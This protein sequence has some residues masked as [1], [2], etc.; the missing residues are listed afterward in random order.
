MV[1]VFCPF[2]LG[3]KYSSSRCR[4]S[5]MQ[6]NIVSVWRSTKLGEMALLGQAQVYTCDL[7]SALLLHLICF[8]ASRNEGGSIE[9]SNMQ[10]DVSND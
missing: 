8:L 1:L 6:C 9:D 4:Y 5:T 10:T 7:F 3:E 2:Y